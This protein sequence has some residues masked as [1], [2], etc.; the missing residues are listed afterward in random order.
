MTLAMLFTHNDDDERRIHVDAGVLHTRLK[1]PLTTH[2]LVFPSVWLHNE[3]AI[4]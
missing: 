1:L 2:I 4:G 3:K